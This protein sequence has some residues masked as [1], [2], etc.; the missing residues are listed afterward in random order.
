[1]IAARRF[2]HGRVAGVECA[3]HTAAS[4]Q[5]GLFAGFPHPV[6]VFILGAHSLRFFIFLR[7]Q[8]SA[9]GYLAILDKSP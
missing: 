2:C 9:A 7:Y 3:T 4:E 6:P 8:T 5:L 1:M